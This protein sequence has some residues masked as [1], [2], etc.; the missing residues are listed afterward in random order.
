MQQPLLSKSSASR[1]E[2]NPTATIAL[3][4]IGGVIYA[5]IVGVFDAIIVEML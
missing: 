2:H 3:Q 1:R 5:I 4:Q